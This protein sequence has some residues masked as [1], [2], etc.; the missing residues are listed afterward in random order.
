MDCLE[1]EK[2]FWQLSAGV[3]YACDW[4]RE[5]RD[6]RPIAS[7]VGTKS[8]HARIN[9]DTRLRSGLLKYFW[10]NCQRARGEIV[11]TYRGDT[12]NN[13]ENICPCE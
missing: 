11:L 9:F 4:L 2:L 8:T 12:E 10:K 3:S 6:F 7:R 5:W 1:R 13:A